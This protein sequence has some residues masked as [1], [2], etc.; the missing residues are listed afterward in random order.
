[1]TL[2]VSNQRAPDRAPLD[3]PLPQRLCSYY[4]ALGQKFWPIYFGREQDFC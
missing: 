4:L 3:I 1:M 2:T